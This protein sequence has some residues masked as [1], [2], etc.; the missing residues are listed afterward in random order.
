MAKPIG[1]YLHI[2]FCRKR[3]AYCDFYSGMV[4]QE[5]CHKYVNRL[6]SE[7]YRWGEKLCRPADTVY[8][9]GGTPSVLKLNDLSRLLN[10]VQT[11]FN[12]PENCEKTIE[13]NPED[14]TEEFLKGLKEAGFNRISFGIQ[15]LSDN[16]LKILGRRHTAADSIKAF[17]TARKVGFDNITVDLMLGLPNQSLE[18]AINT[19][20]KIARLSPEHI[21]CY[22]L[23]LEEKTAL[24]SKREIID[25]PDEETVREEYLNICDIFENSGYNH[26][27]ISNF[28]KEGKESKHNLKY[29]KT[30]EYIGIGPSA[31]S[32]VDG[33][34]F[35]TLSDIHGFIKAPQTVYDEAGGGYEEY[36]MLSLRLKDGL[37][38]QEFEAFTGKTFSGKFREK[39]KFFADNNLAVWSNDTFRLTNEGMLLSNSI[40]CE[41]TEEKL[42]EDL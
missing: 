1:C 26:Y 7:I 23:I 29:W 13:V 20:K 9:G 21:S 32:F 15:T 33:K 27:E 17:N 10:A 36:I 34:R 3:C 37:N 31:Y 19:A 22:M 28:A 24:Y 5:M 12:V 6:E 16:V 41:M 38:R 14:A 2:P 8:L 39:A 4:H 42:Y 25:I 30:Q 11:A 18:E 40:I 35:H